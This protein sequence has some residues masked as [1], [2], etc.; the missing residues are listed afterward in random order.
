M[1]ADGPSR[2]AARCTVTEGDR[3]RAMLL[4]MRPSPLLSFVA[5]T[6]CLL[7]AC[8]SDAAVDNGGAAAGG[9]ATGGTGAGGANAAIGGAAGKGGASGKGGAAGKGASA[10]AGGNGAT[11][12]GGGAAGK[13]AGTGGAG[14]G[15]KGGTS[16][17]GGTAG[18][19][20]MGGSN[21]TAGS[22]G[23]PPKATKPELWYWHHTYLSAGNPK[24]P[25]YSQ[26]LI[27]TAVANGYTGLALWDSSE[28][29]VQQPG[30]DAT[31]LKAVVAYAVQKGLTVL[32]IVAPY[33]YSNDLLKSNPN[34]AEGQ[35]V[36]GTR[37]TVGAGG[38]AIAN[39]LPPLQNGGFEGGKAGWFS[40]GDARVS[41]DG[42]TAH[43]GASAAVIQ[44]APGASDNA[45]LSQAL[46]VTPFRTYHVRF[47]VKSQSLAKG[48]PTVSVL[49]FTTKPNTALAR[50]SR[51]LPI[52]GTT[53]WTRY[54]F[55]FNSRESTK[56]SIYLGI[57][58]GNEG[59]LWVDDIEAE[60]TGLVNV[61]RRGGTPLRVYDPTSGTTYAE[62]SDYGAIADPSLV[63]SPGNYEDW[64]APPAVTIPSGSKLA[65]GQTVAIDHYTVYPAIAGGVGVCLTEPAVDGWMHDNITALDPILPKTSGLFLQYDEMRHMNS[66]DLCRK[67]SLAPGALLA[68]NVAA[69]VATFHAVR[70]G[71]QTYFW[72]DMFDPN[73]NAHDD[74]YYVEGD[75]AGSWKGLPSDAIIMNWNLGNLA[76]SLAWFS[77][78]VAGQPQPYRQIIAGYYDSGDGATAVKQ[79]F[80]A[81]KGIPGV[82]GVMYTTWNDD[83]S[84][85]GPFAAGAL[86]AWKTYP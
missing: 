21:G 33:G 53:D 29:F 59:N 63:S 9:G 66:C 52:Q 60:E 48:A 15:G 44:G 80:A 57:W 85:L 34:L 61:L 14:A 41:I 1:A 19:G 32:P 43:S 86:E 27:D 84:Q 8:G 55:V 6:P 4:R 51:D 16:A 77:G 3:G 50:F 83:Y 39:S 7:L 35:R 65:P 62:G 17:A 2:A 23:L 75:I 42:A 68:G 78:S 36:V 81:A 25:A 20:A 40:I 79:H 24:E 82:I 64:H 74:Y 70:P 12:V 54:D 18:A 72:N 56:V 28:S 22:G 73:H 45:R 69:T 13:G 38:L 76:K 31:K 30:W 10:G 71:A 26:G 5:F 37:Y 49:D 47:W 58:G 46:D 67:K 11:G